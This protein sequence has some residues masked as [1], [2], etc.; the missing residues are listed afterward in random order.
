MKDNIEIL[1]DEMCGEFLNLSLYNTVDVEPEILCVARIEKWRESLWRKTKNGYKHRQRDDADK[2]TMRY[3]VDG[4]VASVG[5]CQG[6]SGGPVFV[7]EG[8]HFVVTGT[9][10]RRT[11]LIICTGN[12]NVRCGKWRKRTPKSMWRS[13]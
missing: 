2:L 5:T 4:Y 7:R 12:F 9:S 10:L 3:N 13:Q 11:H 6:D 8:D 1:P